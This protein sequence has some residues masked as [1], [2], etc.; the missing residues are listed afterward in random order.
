MGAPDGH[1]I[2]PT[3][4]ELITQTNTVAI[5]TVNETDVLN[6]NGF[7]EIIFAEF[8]FASVTANVSLNDVVRLY[9]DGNTIMAH[10]LE[11]FIEE[12]VPA[13]ISPI[14]PRRFR[15]MNLFTIGLKMGFLF[16]RSLR[17]SYEKANAGNMTCYV[18]WNIGSYTPA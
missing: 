12:Y 9:V 18:N 16:A 3:Y 7:G 15:Q 14:I 17:L 6:F 11:R 1:V 4:T 8:R 2:R 10:L 13:D 5:T